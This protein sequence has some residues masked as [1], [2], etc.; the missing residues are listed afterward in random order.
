[1][2]RTPSASQGEVAV[3]AEQPDPP[4][5][6]ASPADGA[7][8]V[9][10]NGPGMPKGP[11]PAPDLG[12]LSIHDARRSARLTDLELHV[13]ERPTDERRWGRVLE[14]Q[15]PPGADVEPGA[16]VRVVIG[17]RPLLRVPDVRG[18]EETEALA[19]LRQAGLEPERRAT[20]HSDKVPEG[21]VLRTRPRAGAEVAIGTRMTYVVADGPR[22][23]GGHPKAS[24]RRGRNG[25]LPDGS[26][27]SLPDE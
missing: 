2:W 1:M 22:A 25:R 24:R 18:R 11:V 12:G 9:A 17:C 23:R 20:R 26:F 8:A 15:P 19:L 13:A 3:P 27:L 10:S 14:Q 16:P 5:P 7:G 4:V 6:A 21:H